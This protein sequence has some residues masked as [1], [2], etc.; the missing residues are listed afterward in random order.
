MHRMHRA[1]HS[2]TVKL[3]AGGDVVQVVT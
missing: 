1:T 2:Q 3:M